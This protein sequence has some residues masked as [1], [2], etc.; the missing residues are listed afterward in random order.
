MS[1]TS[2]RPGYEDVQ[3]LID[4]LWASA[5]RLVQVRDLGQSVQGKTI[6]CAI[7]TDP[8]APA[9]DKQHV[10][11]VAG[12]HGTEES[13]RAMAMALLEDLVSGEPKAAETL[14][15]QVVAVVP[16]ANPDGAVNDTYRNADDVDIAHTYA[17][18]APAGT[19]EGRCLEQFAGQF[20]PD[21]TVDIHGRA[22]GGMKELAW[23]MPA[24]GFSSD[25]YFLTAMSMAMARAG[26][27]AGFP[28]CEFS[29]PGELQRREGNV[30]MLGEKM[31]GQFKS[32]A[33]GLETIEHYYRRA[34]WQATGL[35]RLRR[36]LRFGN[37]DA[38]G[39]GEPGYP[40]CLVSGNRIQGLK[41]HGR[42][43]ERRRANRV[44]LTR[45]LRQ[46]WAMVDRGADGLDRCA[47]V[48]VFSKTCEGENPQRFAILL[49][50]KKPCRIRSVRWRG[51]EM[52]GGDDHGY[53][54]WEDGCSCFCQA[55]IAEPFGGPERF[56]VVGY[57]SPYLPG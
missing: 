39:L 56:L 44:E 35:V 10:L 3:E 38:F 29:P 2:A 18:D 14:A 47:K 9:D 13:G 30:L 26:E 25:R 27:Q 11:V 5:G 19:P 51:R 23:L 7:L 54:T 48:K 4:R 53:R 37:E 16:C 46:N 17:W 1:S 50:F 20:V 24:W 33:L 32:L 12:Q 31:A 36:L 8:A 15:K 57:D 42:T 55:N 41:A 52:S 22:G 34:D 28:Q 6:R 45:F 40:S 49:R 21:V 43:A